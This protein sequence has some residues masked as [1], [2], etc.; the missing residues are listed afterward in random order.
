MVR[1]ISAVTN[2][3]EQ[4]APSTRAKTGYLSN[5]TSSI[6]QPLNRLLTMIVSPGA[7][8]AGG[9]L[10]PG[11]RRPTA[12]IVKGRFAGRDSRLPRKSARQVVVTV[13]S[14]EIG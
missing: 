4:R 9:M 6:R 1:R 5:Q 10:L 11:R 3:C 7:Q 13:D 8:T 12:S 14:A 2:G